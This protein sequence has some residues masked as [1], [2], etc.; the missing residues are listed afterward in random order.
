MKYFPK[1]SRKVKSKYFF[2]VQ[3]VTSQEDGLPSYYDV[4]K[5][6]QKYPLN[7]PSAKTLVKPDPTGNSDYAQKEAP[8]TY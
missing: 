1:F 5:E 2:P 3:A 7:K 8:P 4:V 6:P